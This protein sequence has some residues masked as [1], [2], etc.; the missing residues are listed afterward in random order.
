MKCIEAKEKIV[1]EVPDILYDESRFTLGTPERVYYPESIDDI[2]SV[3][4][5]AA[6]TQT[7]VTV[8]GGQTGITGG[9]VPTEGCIALCMSAMHSVL[10][11]EKGR[12]GVPVLRCQP[13]ITLEQIAAFLEKPTD[14]GQPVPGMELLGET[15]WFYPPDPTEMSAQLG[16]TVA[17]NASGA[18]TFR[19]GATRRHIEL[20]TI[21]TA[22][23][24]TATIRRGEH[25]FA[26]GACT[27]KTDQGTA[28]SIRAPRYQSGT[29]KNA[30]GYYSRPGMDLIDL[31]VGSEGTLCV[32][33]EVGIRLSPAPRLTAGLTF[34]PSRESA[35]GFAVF[36]RQERPVLAVEYFDSTALNFIAEYK[37][38]ITLKLPAFPADAHAAVY[39]EYT[40]TDD[41]PFEE[42]MEVWEEQ[43]DA[44]GTS[45]ENTWSGFEPEESTRL[46]KFRHAAPELVNFKI[47]QYKRETADIR[48]VGSDTAVPGAHF[49]ELFS[50][51]FELI[52]AGGP[53]AVV[54][55]HLG[56]YHLHFNMLPRTTAEMKKAREIYGRMMDLALELGGTVSAEHGI[57]K[58]KT[59]YLARMYGDEG[60]ADMRTIKETLDPSGLLNPGNLLPYPP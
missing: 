45:L 11:V 13:G 20:L 7:P 26:D 39:W 36:L 19:M 35:F 60:I 24:E 43:L 33:A 6:S 10:A 32:F 37:D 5:E 51:Y 8:I 56:D 49:E 30:A 3:I 14:Y 29:F 47:A 18:R 27:F 38:D 57:G 12:E 9:S 21:V 46:K 31:L 22:K 4:V 41:A 1:A 59:D 54:F 50:R 17:A 25:L 58:L 40:E 23:G 28:Y 15:V 52:S 53:R 34:L 48:K 42:R 16:G 55:G 44:L 2:R